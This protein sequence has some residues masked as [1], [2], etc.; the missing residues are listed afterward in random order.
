MRILVD[1]D[2]VL[3]GFDQAVH[4][5]LSKRFPPEKVIALENRRSFYYA[6]DYPEDMHD[7]INQILNTE[8]F[9]RSL[10]VIPGAIQAVKEMIAEG[11]EVTICTSPLI[12]APNCAAEK[13][14]WITEHLGHEWLNRT[15]ITRDKTLVRGDILIDDKPEITGEMKPL[16]QHV[17]FDAPYNRQVPNPLR[18]HD[19]TEWR[20]VI[21]QVNTKKA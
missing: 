21:A 13:F 18:I 9:H 2:G 14:G 4:T 8:G 10:P 15:I 19:W 5:A 3:S 17:I 12:S 20:N 6:G 11:H 7:I 16:W 1:Q